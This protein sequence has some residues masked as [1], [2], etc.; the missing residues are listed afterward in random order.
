MYLSP[1]FFLEHNVKF[2]KLCNSTRSLQECKLSVCSAFSGVANVVFVGA[3][4]L[5]LWATEIIKAL[6]K[7]KVNLLVIDLQV[8]K[9]LY[10]SSV[11][12][13]YIKQLPFVLFQ[14]MKS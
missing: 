1:K 3:G 11:L 8:V 9:H 14:R 4:G 6:Y 5:S 2:Q 7:E 13:N 10:F 12:T